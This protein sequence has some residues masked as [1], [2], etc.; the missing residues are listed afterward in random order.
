MQKYTIKDVVKLCFD[1]YKVGD[2]F[3]NLFSH[4]AAR[5]LWLLWR[6]YHIVDDSF[7]E[8]C[9]AIG[10]AIDDL[11]P[12]TV[13]ELERCFRLGFGVY[14]NFAGGTGSVGGNDVTTFCEAALPYFIGEKSVSYEII[15]G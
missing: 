3:K 1:P 15:E 14:G 9:L 11:K 13:E 10:N 7:I 8:E 5:K 12:Q 4:E 6:P 2:E